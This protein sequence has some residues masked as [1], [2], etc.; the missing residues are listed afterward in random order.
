MQSIAN[1]SRLVQPVCGIPIHHE[2]GLAEVAKRCYAAKRT[3]DGSLVSGAIQIVVERDAALARITPVQERL[4]G[5]IR[6]YQ[7]EVETLLRVVLI[8]HI[9]NPEARSPCAA[10]IAGTQVLQ[11]IGLGSLRIAGVVVKTVER[12]RIQPR[13]PAARMKV[14]QRCGNLVAG[15]ERLRTTIDVRTAVGRK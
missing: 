6:W 12:R 8:E 1:R 10:M 7:A 11:V 4:V 9:A 14:L 5:E 3:F 2:C 13:K 15:R